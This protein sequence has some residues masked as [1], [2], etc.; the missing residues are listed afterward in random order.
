MKIFATIAKS[1]AVIDTYFDDAVKFAHPENLQSDAKYETYLL[2]KTINFT[3]NYRY[4]F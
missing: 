4:M 3:D 1:V 2:C